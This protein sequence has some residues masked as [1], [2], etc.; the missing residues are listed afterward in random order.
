MT[1]APIRYPLGSIPGIATIVICAIAAELV[2]HPHGP[3]PALT[4]A[5]KLID[6]RR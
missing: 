2:M 6:D 3:L 4:Q 5:V 1:P